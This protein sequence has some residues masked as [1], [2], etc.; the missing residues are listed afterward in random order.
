MDAIVAQRI[1]DYV[2]KRQRQNN[3]ELQKGKR[4]IRALADRLPA[5]TDPVD[6]ML[7]K[8]VIADM[9]KRQH[10]LKLSN[11]YLGVL[12]SNNREDTNA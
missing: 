11:N 2:E 6:R 9:A 7:V 3:R 12:L 1:T 4:A 5:T 8:K 10:Y